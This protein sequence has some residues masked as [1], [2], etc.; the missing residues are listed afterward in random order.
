MMKNP[1]YF[2]LK[3]FFVFKILKFLSQGG[4]QK[5]RSLKIREF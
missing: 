3:A 2:I 4:I 1:L 5:V